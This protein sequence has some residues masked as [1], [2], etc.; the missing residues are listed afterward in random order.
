MSGGRLNGRRIVITG[1]AGG[2]GRATATLFAEEGASVALLDRNGAA[3]SD[4]AQALD[5]FATPCDVTRPDEIDHAIAAAEA[6]LGG[7]DGLINAAGLLRVKP[8]E[9]SAIEDWSSV[10]DVNLTGTMLMCRAIL[11]AFRRAGRGTIVNIASIAALKPP[12]ASAAY[13]VSKAGVLMLS[14]CLANELGPD[15]RVNSVCPGTIETDM[16]ASLRQDNAV[17]QRLANMAAAKRFGTPREVAQAL[18][19]LTSDEAAFV[20]GAALGVDG[21]AAFH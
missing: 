15:I 17:A 14:R 19:F 1:A 3:L 4:A 21:G 6:A 18:L 10:I 8:F 2:I 11:P 7:L 5:A 13:A 9:S 16:T 12:P 20:T